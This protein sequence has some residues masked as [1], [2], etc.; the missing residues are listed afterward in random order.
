VTSSAATTTAACARA[1]GSSPSSQAMLSAKPRPGGASRYEEPVASGSVRRRGHRPRRG[2]PPI[3]PPCA[4]TRP[5]AIARPRPEPPFRGCVNRPRA[6][7]ARTSGPGPCVRSQLRLSLSRASSARRAPRR[8]AA[9]RP[10]RPCGRG[11]RRFQT[12]RTRRSFRCSGGAVDGR[13]G[14][15]EGREEDGPA[16][17]QVVNDGLLGLLRG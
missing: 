10:P 2:S 13:R 3:L 4:S 1:S 17:A 16:R 8:P 9:G 7:S 11:S 6:R 12:A 15:L 5:C 14:G